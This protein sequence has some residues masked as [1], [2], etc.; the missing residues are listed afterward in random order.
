MSDVINM[1]AKLRVA[2]PNPDKK[3][4]TFPHEAVAGWRMARQAAVR[5][6]GCKGTIVRVEPDSSTNAK[7]DR[8]T[9]QLDSTAHYTHREDSIVGVLS[10]S[11][12]PSGEFKPWHFS[13]RF[14]REAADSELLWGELTQ[15]PTNRRDAGHEGLG[16]P[17]CVAMGE[18]G[19]VTCKTSAHAAGVSPEDDGDVVEEKNPR[20]NREE[21]EPDLKSGLIRRNGR[22]TEDV[23]RFARRRIGQCRHHAVHNEIHNRLCAARNGRIGPA[24]ALLDKSTR[25][26]RSCLLRSCPCALDTG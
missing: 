26:P 5:Y 2:I 14:R 16:L 25:F 7:F 24:K 17:G 6:H 8:F 13:V 3:G 4:R 15:R 18:N 9:I 21:E 20:K 10:V 1:M 22:N 11:T 23:V 12:L 19:R